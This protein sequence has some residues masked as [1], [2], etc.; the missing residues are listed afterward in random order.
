[1]IIKTRQQVT[2][3]MVCSQKHLNLF[4]NGQSKF[5]CFVTNYAEYTFKMLKM[6]HVSIRAICVKLQNVNSIRVFKIITKW[7]L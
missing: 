6:E 7:I 3:K 2:E 5:V 4:L 1:M